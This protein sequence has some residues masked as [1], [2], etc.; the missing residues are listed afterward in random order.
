M[1]RKS[2]EIK[3]GSIVWIEVA[4]PRGNIKKRPVVV[5]T[6]TDEIVIDQEI[7][8][9]AVTTSFRDPLDQGCVKLPSW[10][11]GH[12]AT[13]LR[14]ESVAVCD[15]RVRFRPSDVTA[16]E[17]YVPARTLLRIVEKI[18]ELDQQV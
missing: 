6:S 16:V 10:P 7:V 12:P 1:D 18:N 14:R 9:V 4:D 15:W 17:G 11:F 8:G 13:G 3:R 5:V 2:T